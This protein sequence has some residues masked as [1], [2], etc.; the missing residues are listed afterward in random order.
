M[1]EKE[2]L[3]AV[4]II[5]TMWVGHH[6]T[7]FKW[8]IKTLLEL[9]YEVWAFCPQP[10][11]VLEWA[12]ENT[13]KEKLQNL[14]C[15]A[16]TELWEYRNNYGN[17]FFSQGS[18][19]L[20]LWFLIKKSLLRLS[21]LRGKNPNFVFLP[22][23]DSWLSGLMRSF[24]L[25]KIFPFAWSGIYFHPLHLRGLIPPK[26]FFKRKLRKLFFEDGALSPDIT[27]SSKHC[28]S[29]CVLDENILP[30]LQK[31]IRKKVIH[32]PDITDESLP[33]MKWEAVC[34]IQKRANGRK[35]IGLLGGLDRRK[36]I[37]TLYEIAKR[38]ID[39]EYFF[40]FAGKVEY[41]GAEK[42]IELFNQMKSSLIT[43]N[44]IF[45]YFQRVPDGPKFNALVNTCD[46][47]FAAYE[48]FPY[49]S[50]LL[51]K[52]SLFK[53]PVIVTK[54]ALLEERVRKYQ[55]GVSIEQ[56]NFEEGIRAIELLLDNFNAKNSP[57]YDEYFQIHSQHRLKDVFS[58]MLNAA[59][60]KN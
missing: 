17:N 36:G 12:N 14:Y 38:T 6:P 28:K 46:I 40:V 27:F 53:K 56:N 35:I 43:Q 8:I 11:E 49:S 1:L 33:D 29:I 4:A 7:Y 54:G 16:M 41:S 23:I 39:R 20:M 58:E 50:N 60:M 25:D 44:N 15:K 2:N 42:D 32:F 19:S 31:R 21:D 22:K 37:F 47:I 3:E 51:T 59:M 18:N 9:N 26:N 45:C 52:A 57:R 55:I 10:Q 30:I 5:D 13:E 34:E 48:N 24:L